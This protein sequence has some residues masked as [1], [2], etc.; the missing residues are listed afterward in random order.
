MD[1]LKDANGGLALE[2]E[3]IKVRDTTCTVNLR[4]LSVDSAQQQLKLRL[5]VKAPPD[6]PDLT[7]TRATFDVSYFDFPMIDNTRLVG[8]DRCAIVLNGFS[9]YSADITVVMFP[10]AYASLKEKPYYNEVIQSVLNASKK[11]KD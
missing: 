1:D 9:N 6:R 7:D 3:K 4:V 11:E 5:E 8:G 10:G 2:G